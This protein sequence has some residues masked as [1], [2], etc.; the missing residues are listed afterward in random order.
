MSKTKKLLFAALTPIVGL[1][2]SVLF[3]GN[4][5]SNGNGTPYT[6]FLAPVAEANWIICDANCAE[7]HGKKRCYVEGSGGAC[8]AISNPNG[9]QTCR[10]HSTGSC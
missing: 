6:N 5:A 3:T 8:I 2:C 1:A 7:I 9:T 10:N 4:V